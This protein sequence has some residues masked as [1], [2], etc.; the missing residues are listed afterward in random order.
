MFRGC[1]KIGGWA[2][3]WGCGAYPGIPSSDSHGTRLAIDAG[4]FGAGFGV[5]RI[6][7]AGRPGADGIFR[8]E[9]GLAG[10]ASINLW[11]VEAGKLII[12]RMR[13]PRGGLE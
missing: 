6:Y 10:G 13:M 9:D 11:A 1:E 2:S 7:A 3:R 4:A 5:T 8:S 12:G